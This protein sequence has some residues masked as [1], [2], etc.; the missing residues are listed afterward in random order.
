MALAPFLAAGC[1]EP[2]PAAPATRPAATAAVPALGGDPPAAVPAPAPA[3][4]ASGTLRSPLTGL[5]TD[6]TLLRRRIVAVKIDNAPLAR[7]Q[8]GLSQ[9]EVVYEHLA[10]GGVTRFLALYLAHEPE[11]VG[12]VRSA[13]LVDLYLGQEWNFL[14]AYAGA[15][16]T[17]GQLLAEALIPLFKAPELGERLDGTPFFRDPSRTVPHNMFVRVPE[18]RVEASRTPGIESEVE[19]RGLPFQPEPGEP[20]PIR[21][22]TMPYVVPGA[23]SWQYGVTWRFDEPTGT[24][25]RMMAGAP[26]VDALSGEQIAVQNV[27]LQFAET[28]GAT[29]VERDAAGNVAL[30]VVLRGENRAV[31]FHSGHVFEGTWSKEHDRAQTQYRLPSGDPLPF[32]PGHTWIHI[33]PSDFQPTWT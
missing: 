2:K 13:R 3:E 28:S 20:G 12:P 14:L 18:V 8:M 21:L 16:T 7:P 27:L 25:K 1:G 5:E 19:I 30:D 11:R 29:H 31:L 22:I 17:T 26:H 32:H 15:G 24:W 9:A 33:L 6:A 4:A 10:E 23:L